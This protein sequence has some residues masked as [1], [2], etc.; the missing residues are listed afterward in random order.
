MSKPLTLA[1]ICVV[2][3]SLGLAGTLPPANCAADGLVKLGR[4]E[5]LFRDGRHAD[6]VECVTDALSRLEEAGGFGRSLVST[7]DRAVARAHSIRA[8]AWACLANREAAL[9]DAAAALGIVS[10][11]EFVTTFVADAYLRVGEPHQALEVCPDPATVTGGHARI[12]AVEVRVAAL[13]STGSYA[14]AKALMQ[15]ELR[16]APQAHRMAMCFG[17]IA[18]GQKDWS[19]AADCYRAACASQATDAE[20]FAQ[21]G[22]ALARIEKLRGEARSALEHALELSPENATALTARA[23]LAMAEGD[24][25]AARTWSG[26]ACEAAPDSSLAWCVR[27]IAERTGGDLASARESLTRAVELDRDPFVPMRELVRTHLQLNERE[28]ALQVLRRFAARHPGHSGVQ[29]LAQE[30]GLTL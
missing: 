11:D 22:T 14:A 13:S 20:A 27:G 5:G 25:A 9:A 7:D 23:Y 15:S 1:L 30:T 4:A 26:R 17:G 12:E 16:N 6:A 29:E 24:V 2:L 3:L 18:R 10:G 8:R 19:F 28:E 21:L